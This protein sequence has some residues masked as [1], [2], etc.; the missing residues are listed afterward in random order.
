[1]IVTDYEQKYSGKIK[2]I[3]NKNNENYIEVINSSHKYFHCIMKYSYF[4][5]CFWSLGD[6]D[7]TNKIKF[8]FKVSFSVNHVMFTLHKVYKH[9]KVS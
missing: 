5:T 9:A 6:E 2:N 8:Q 3:F 1:M 7:M 4:T